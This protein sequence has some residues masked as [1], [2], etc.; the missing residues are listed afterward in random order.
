MPLKQLCPL[1]LLGTGA[2]STVTLCLDRNTNSTIVVKEIP[3]TSYDEDRFANEVSINKQV[4]CDQ[5]IKIMGYFSTESSFYLLLEPGRCD[6]FAR[7]ESDGPLTEAVS[8][9]VFKDLLTAVSQL[10]QRNIVHHDIK[11]EN[12]IV[13]ESG[14]VKLAD[15]GLAEIVNDGKTLRAR[16]GT[17]KYWAPE[18]VLGKPHDSKA[19]VWAIG[20]CLYASLT[21]AFPFSGEDEYDYTMGVIWDAPELEKINASQDAVEIVRS[22][23]TRAARDRPTVAELLKSKWLADG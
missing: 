22:M 13:L 18:V 21:G 4:V 19:D 11:L 15:F 9:P 20:V 10:H 5:I 14:A 23:L 12:L 16:K 1:R 2:T 17:Y 3:R 8:K 7:I 6:L